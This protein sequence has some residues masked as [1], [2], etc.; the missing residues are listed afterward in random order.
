MTEVLQIIVMCHSIYY[1][2]L[3]HLYSNWWFIEDPNNP[4]HV[5]GLYTL[6]TNS[7]SIY[8]GDFFDTKESGRWMFMKNAIRGIHFHYS[9]DLER[10]SKY[11]RTARFLLKGRKICKKYCTPENMKCNNVGFESF[12]IA[13]ILHN[14][15]HHMAAKCSS[16]LMSEHTG[17]HKILGAA[18]VRSMLDHPHREILVKS[19]FKNSEIPW[20]RRMHKELALVDEEYADMC[21]LGIRF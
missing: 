21:H 1:H 12:F 19:S 4:L 18:W 14:V 5:Y 10:F 2:I 6:L 17:P 11:S 13:C 3:I 16:P 9:A 15:D 20:I 7:I 8:F